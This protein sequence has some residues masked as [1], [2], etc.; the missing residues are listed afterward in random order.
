MTVTTDQPRRLSYDD[1]ALVTAVEG[2]DRMAGVT[3]ENIYD[4][5]RRDLIQPQNWD[6]RG[7]PLYSMRDL[8]NTEHATRN[9]QGARRV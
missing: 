4:W 9:G 6:S 7:R 8:W 3:A 1:E 5:K 2:A